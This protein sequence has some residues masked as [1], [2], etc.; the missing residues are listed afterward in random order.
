MRKM[1]SVLLA[2]VMILGFASTQIVFAESKFPVKPV[3]LY[4]G[5][6]AGGSSDMIARGLVVE[7][8]R[9]LGQKILVV[10]K[11]GAGGAVAAALLA[12]SKPD[13]YSIQINPDTPF[14]RAPHLRKLAFDPMND[15]TF[16]SRVAVWKNG[17]VV[18]ADSPFK[19]W[20]DVV[21]WAKEN[22]GELKYGCPGAGT[23]PDLVMAVIAKREG[24]TYRSSPF[25]GDSP[26]MAAVLGGHITVGGSGLGAWS[27]YV[28]ANQMRVL[29]V[30]EGVDGYPGVPTYKELGYDLV[31]PTAALIFGPK[32]MPED[33]VKKLGEVFAAAVKSDAFKM[34]ADAMELKEIDN[35]LSGPEL[36]KYVKN[37]Y[38]LFKGYVE[39]AGLKKQ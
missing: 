15:F 19:T 28:K 29:M 6:A 4:V 17:F 27:K 7:G 36:E 2:A 13:G 33:V 31:S 25:K 30:E 3:T 9:A 22:P 24:F 34:V 18:K 11:P 37:A 20:K 12:K 21:K 35:P 39:E 16:I 23:T 32:G 1:M 5:F 14:T 10:N 38:E 26:A 8:E